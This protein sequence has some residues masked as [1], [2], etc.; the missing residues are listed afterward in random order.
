MAVVNW[1]THQYVNIGRFGVV[2]FFLVSGYII[3]FSLERG[4]SVRRFAVGRFFRLYPLYWVSLV[5]ILV[6]YQFQHDA[7][8]AGLP[9]PHVLHAV[10]NF[11]MIQELRRR[12]RTRSACTTR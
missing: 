10:V 4:G 9:D 7:L 5:A 6:I 2:A 12:A 3:P 1:V 8:D 11:T